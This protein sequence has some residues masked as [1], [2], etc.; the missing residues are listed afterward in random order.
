MGIIGSQTAIIH[1]QVNLRFHY[2]MTSMDVQKIA[3]CIQVTYTGPYFNSELICVGLETQVVECQVSDSRIFFGIVLVLLVK[4]PVF[5]ITVVVG[6]LYV[7]QEKNEIKNN[8]IMKKKDMKILCKIQRSCKI[9]QDF[10]FFLRLLQ[11]A[12][13]KN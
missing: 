8:E 12:G 1:K 7:S 4:D 3:C 6:W 13:K 5:T 9:N 10:R 11:L 2:Y